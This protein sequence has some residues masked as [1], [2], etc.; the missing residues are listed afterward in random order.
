MG[1][2]IYIQGFREKMIAKH[3][4][5]YDALIASAFKFESQGLH[6]FKTMALKRAIDVRKVMTHYSY[7][8][9]RLV[10]IVDGKASVLPDADILPFHK[11]AKSG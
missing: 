4:V 7:P 10:Y 1:E 8:S 2:V 9:K 5:D 11:V 6:V 3:R